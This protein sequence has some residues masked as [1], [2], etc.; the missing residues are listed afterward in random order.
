[1]F[2]SLPLFSTAVALGTIF[3]GLSKEF[4]SLKLS[5]VRIIIFEPEELIL[6]T[7]KPLIEM[8]TVSRELPKFTAYNR[9]SKRSDIYSY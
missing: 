9:D 5:D 2:I 4:S 6:P 3:S 1:M 7:G 8:S